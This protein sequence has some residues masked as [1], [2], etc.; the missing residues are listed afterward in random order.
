MKLL[1]QLLIL[2]LTIVLPVQGIAGVSMNM[3]M[4]SMDT[5][6][7]SALGVH[8]A[9]AAACHHHTDESMTNG[10]DD[11]ASASDNCPH[12]FALAH[13]IAAPSRVFLPEHMPDEVIVLHSA[14]FSS[15]IPLPPLRPPLSLCS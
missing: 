1:R 13:F 10:M 14:H 8:D 11:S 2:L 15:H 9:M 6:I 7:Q 5:G 12:C 3:S 4:C